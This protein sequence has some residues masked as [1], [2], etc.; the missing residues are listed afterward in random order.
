M[1]PLTVVVVDDA[2]DYRE[3]VRFLLLSIPTS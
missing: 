3:V 2:L 1:P